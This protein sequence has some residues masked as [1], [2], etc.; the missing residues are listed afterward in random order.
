MSGS[1]K[2]GGSELIN[3]NGGSGSLQW[4]TGVPTGAIIQVKQTIKTDATSKT[5]TNQSIDFD[6]ISGMSCAITP[7]TGSK[8]LVHSFLNLGGDTGYS[9]NIRL[10]RGSTP[11]CVGTGQQSSQP[12][13][14]SH[15]RTSSSAGMEPIT[16]LF[17]DESPGGDG[18]TSITYKF[19]WDGEQGSPNRVM[20]LN[21]THYDGNSYTHG[22][23]AS[24][25]VLMEIAG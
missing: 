14:T 2:V 17:L 20:Y 25:I 10:L 13:G 18:S 6:D 12:Q 22:R 5:N 4:G 24:T 21:Q 1:L 11:V 23:Y 19:Q 9:N 16:V 15:F 3:D 8:V 7:R